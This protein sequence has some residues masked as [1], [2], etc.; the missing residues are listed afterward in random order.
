M[1]KKFKGIINVDLDGVVYDFHHACQQWIYL[2]TLE[3][4]DE[5]P[6]WTE[7]NGEFERW[8]RLGVE[9]GAIWGTAKGFNW[10]PIDGARKYMWMLSDAEY[11]IRLV[12]TRLVQSFNHKII[13]NNT[14]DWLDHHNIPY[15][16]ICF[17]G[18]DTKKSSF[19][20]DYAI[21]DRPEHTNDYWEHHVDAMLY[22]QPYNEGA[23]VPWRGGWEDFT[24]Y[25]IH[26]S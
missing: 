14:V 6:G 19:L 12:T 16:E 3:R 20:C 8:W 1:N 17:L 13:V 9:A 21:D 7:P 2:Q 5:I 26:E 11:Y 4:W 10:K 25:I 15:R 24:Q 23:K 22:S 18:W